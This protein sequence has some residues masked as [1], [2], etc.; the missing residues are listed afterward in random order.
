MLKFRKCLG[1]TT[2][3]KIFCLAI[4]EIVSEYP[5]NIGYYKLAVTHKSLHQKFNDIEISNERLEFLG[6]AILGSIVANYLYQ[7]FPTK[8]EGFLTQLRSKIVKRETLNILAKDVGLDKIIRTNVTNLSNTNI[9]GDAFEAFVG[10]LYLDKGYDKTARIVID[11]FVKQHLDIRTL[12]S[13]DN[14]FKS[15]IINHCQKNKQ[16]ITYDTNIVSNENYF[17]SC[18]LIDNKVVGKGRGSS[19]KQAEQDASKHAIKKIEN[20]DG[21]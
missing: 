21:V 17:I 16:E 11:V 10:A 12:I 3:D 15:R 5:K 7:I 1:S 18:I 6:D 13:E 19:K 8:D 2:E 9:L 20:T 4:K 14:D